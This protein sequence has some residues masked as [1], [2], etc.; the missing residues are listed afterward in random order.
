M[1]TDKISFAF[2]GYFL[3]Y[4]HSPHLSDDQRSS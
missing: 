2:M 3:M 4:K 1:R